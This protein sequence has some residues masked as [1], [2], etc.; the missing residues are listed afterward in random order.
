[1]TATTP[2]APAAGFSESVDR[3]GAMVR[4]AGHLNEQ[5]VDLVLGA[6]EVLRREGHQRITLDLHAVESADDEVWHRM[7]CVSARAS[8]PMARGGRQRDSNGPAGN[9]HKAK[10]DK[11][12]YGR[13]SGEHERA[14]Q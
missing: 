12:R 10:P 14:W 6:V 1:M 5:G 13:P 2:G 4:C 7:H 11:K 8:L 9:R 3:E